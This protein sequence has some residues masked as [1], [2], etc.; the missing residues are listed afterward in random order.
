MSKR[1]LIT[2]LVSIA[3]ILPAALVWHSNRGYTEQEYISFASHPIEE[4]QV[5]YV[6]NKFAEFRSMGFGGAGAG[7]IAI[8][9]VDYLSFDKFLQD[10][11]DSIYVTLDPSYSWNR[12]TKSYC[13]FVDDNSLLISYSETYK[14]TDY[15]Y[16]DLLDYDADG[17]LLSKPDA[18]ADETAFNALMICFLFPVYW[19]PIR[20]GAYGGQVK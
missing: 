6:T 13:S 5:R 8:P 7:G 9:E 14:A 12:V 11:D 18:K 16:D 19:F 2:I 3:V 15:G 1:T 20:L 10:A 4:H 17:F